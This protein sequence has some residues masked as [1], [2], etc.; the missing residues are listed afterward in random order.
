MASRRKEEME[1]GRDDPVSM[2]SFDTEAESETDDDLLYEIRSELGQ[3]ESD[4]PPQW[5]EARSHVSTPN[6]STPPS[7]RRRNGAEREAIQPFGDPLSST[8]THDQPRLRDERSG[9]VPSRQRGSTL[10]PEAA[11]PGELAAQSAQLIAQL[12]RFIQER[13]QAL[14]SPGNEFVIRR[15]PLRPFDAGRDDHLEGRHGPQA[16]KFLGTAYAKP[17]RCA[18]ESMRAPGAS[19]DE[20]NR[21]ARQFSDMCS[22]LLSIE[23]ELFRGNCRPAGP[24]GHHV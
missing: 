4:G 24:L 19:R 1:S 21:A 3:H 20:G 14:R 18:I 5:A 11:N 16:S 6:S 9:A 7:P 22:R 12:Q 8:S 15:N 17:G 2:R 13:E 10:D 23:G